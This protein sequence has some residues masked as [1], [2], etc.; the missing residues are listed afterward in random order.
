[1]TKV[2]LPDTNDAAL[3]TPGDDLNMDVEGEKSPVEET[4]KAEGEPT[5]GE[6]EDV[7][8]DQ[9]PE[10]TEIASEK[11]EEIPFDE[12]SQVP[13][14]KPADGSADPSKTE[15][16]AQKGVKNEDIVEAAA[17]KV[18][19]VLAPTKKK[20]KKSLI[21]KI[22]KGKKSKKK[23]SQKES[24]LARDAQQLQKASLA[25][26]SPSAGATDKTTDSQVEKKPNEVVNP[27]DPAQSTKAK[28]EAWRSN[29]NLSAD[30]EPL[31]KT[32]S[33]DFDILMSKN[34]ADNNW[35]E[36][37]STPLSTPTKPVPSASSSSPT[38]VADF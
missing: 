13:K 20:K 29:K 25:T 7:T 34:A 23:T 17:P 15:N 8:V 12:T 37:T 16:E 2:F 3:S 22:F 9:T 10:E 18:Q 31:V 4:E 35:G 28:R 24:V 32:D 27:M 6:A 26:E 19:A 5:D 14:E 33:A 11:T 36:S 1:M 30:S 21:S 38:G